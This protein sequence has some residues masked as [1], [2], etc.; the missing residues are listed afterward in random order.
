VDDAREVDV[1]RTADGEITY[2][3]CSRGHH[4]V[5][6]GCGRTMEMYGPVV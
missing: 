4:Q 5:R 2:Q 1:L 6:H 3:R